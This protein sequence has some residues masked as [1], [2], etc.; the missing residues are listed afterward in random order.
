MYPRGEAIEHPTEPMLL[1][2]T[3]EGCPVNME[4]NWTKEEIVVAAHRGP[5]TSALKLDAIKMMHKEVKDK[6][7]EGF[8][9]IVNPADIEH[10]LGTE[11]WA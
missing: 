11:E 9:E 8:A 5:H 10:L 4:K 6:V 7:T 1:Q 2:Y 3:R